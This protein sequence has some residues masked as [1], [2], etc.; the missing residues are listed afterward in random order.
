MKISS[1]INILLCTLL[2]FNVI[3]AQTLEEEELWTRQKKKKT[4]APKD[5][6]FF[7]MWEEKEQT[8]E[9][10]DIWKQQREQKIQGRLGKI[11]ALEKAI[12]PE[13]YI[14]G[15][16][17]ILSFN[18][19]GAME[20]QIPLP[21]SPEGKLSVPS[22]G[23]IDVDG[24]SLAAVH[25]LVLEEASKYYENNSVSLVLI[26]LRFF[27]VH[28]TGEVEFP[29]TFHAQATDRISE[30][31]IED[32][33]TT[34]WAWKRR[35]ELRHA[36]DS[37]DYCDLSRFEQSG[38]L[39]EDLYVGGGDV[40]YVPPIELQDNLVRVEGDIKSAGLYQILGDEDLLYFLQRIRALKRN[41]DL[42]KIAVIR[43]NNS[44][45]D[46][47]AYMPLTSDIKN[48]QFILKDGD[49]VIL[50]SDYVYVKGTVRKPGAYPYVLNMRARDYA[51]MAGGDYRSGS[52]KAIKVFHARTGK[53]EKG[54]DV[55]VD[56]G[57]IVEV[58]QTFELK[59]RE[60]LSM[61]SAL[62]YV[63]VAY[64]TVENLTNK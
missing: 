19:W 53:T 14:I 27:R 29:G 35:I 7:K 17:D 18:I 26:S 20:A 32:G 5:V 43:N 33:G 58:P 45:E 16:G 51:G 28:V 41:T 38:N 36:N 21:V 48:S 60:I 59:L 62:A 31:I 4:L 12:D 39:E 25:D 55:L 54:E 11:A 30:L 56:P 10:F 47:T 22:V 13:K 63:F 8:R 1:I 34:E 46:N 15:P 50:P 3:Q 6:D 42:S 64:A 37:T 57:D 9:D 44:T 49:R 52:I 24:K 23:D 61:I 40:I 2:M